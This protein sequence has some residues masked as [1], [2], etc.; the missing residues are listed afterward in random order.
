MAKLVIADDELITLAYLKEIL[1]E[2]GHTVLASCNNGVKAVEAAFEHQP[3]LVLL[4]INMPGE[5]NGIEAASRILDKVGCPV[6]FITAYPLEEFQ[7]EIWGSAPFG[8]IVKPFNRSQVQANIQIALYR[9]QM[10]SRLKAS[11]EKH[12]KALEDEQF[13]SSLLLDVN[14]KDFEKKGVSKIL[15][16][17]Q[18]YFNLQAV[19]VYLL[20][21]DE[22]NFNLF[23]LAL[24]EYLTNSSV[25][26]PDYIL[27]S[28]V[29][30]NILTDHKKNYIITDLSFLPPKMQELSK[31]FQ[32]DT[33][34]LTPLN[35]KDEFYG[36][37]F[38][39]NHKQRHFKSLKNYAQLFGFS[40]SAL[41]KRKRDQERILA[42]EKEKQKQEKMLMR[43]ERLAGFAT[44]TSGITH[45]IAQPLQSMKFVTASLISDAKKDKEK[46]EIADIEK[47]QSKVSQITDIV[48]NMRY[49]FKSPSKIEIKDFE[50]NYSIRKV[51]QILEH[52]L[53]KNGI[54][55]ITKLNKEIRTLTF[56]E[57]QFQQILINLV[58]NA[59]NALKDSLYEEKEII[60]ITEKTE[61]AVILRV[62]DSGPGIPNEIKEQIFDPFFSTKKD[63]DNMGM[64]LYIVHNILKAYG[65]VI[66]IQDRKPKG[67]IFEVYFYYDKMKELFLN[68]QREKQALI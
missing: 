57:V 38:C 17:F 58:S 14:L 47:L 30:E 62:E 43:I 61:D 9:K 64:G 50:L 55:C 19:S 46:I 56:S 24:G 4:D 49:L 44:L 34:L 51:V 13:I 29:S 37:L 26:L 20:D 54:E 40:I 65:A 35:V 53:R 41:I 59:I 63:K 18:N 42:V 22:T 12:Q 2:I 16:A 45:E 66:H 39:L 28:D 6:I 15:K 7:N 23:S 36:F 10:E 33:A 25:V 11:I 21:K 31:V 68:Q 48:K 3:D 32:F 67:T 60:I 27:K 1:K 5:Y 8:Y 52:K